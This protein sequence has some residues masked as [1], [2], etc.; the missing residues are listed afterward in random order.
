MRFIKFSLNVSKS[1]NNRKKQLCSQ[2][3][4]MYTHKTVSGKL[5]EKNN[6]INTLNCD[7]TI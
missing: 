6:K 1:K 2:I 7:N 5:K 3:N 4:A